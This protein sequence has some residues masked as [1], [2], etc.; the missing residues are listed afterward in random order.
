MFV[1]QQ[2]TVEVSFACG[3]EGT[4]RARI[5]FLPGVDANVALENVLVRGAIGAVGAAEWHLNT[6]SVDVFLQQV[7]PGRAVRAVWTGKGP[8][9][10][11]SENV[12]LKVMDKGCV[13]ATLGTLVH[14][15]GRGEA[16]PVPSG[17]PATSPLT[18]S[19]PLHL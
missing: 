3:S 13:V 12:S 1:G 10:C 16:L 2:V 15:V 19:L 18:V 8:L 9:S 17:S 14:S 7:F 4:V 6:V 11:V 5:R